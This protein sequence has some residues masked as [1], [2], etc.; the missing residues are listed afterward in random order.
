MSFMVMRSEY[1]R[2][3]LLGFAAKKKLM[4]GKY[5][6][7]QN[8]EKKAIIFYII[9]VYIYNIFIAGGGALVPYGAFIS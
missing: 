5:K 8:W 7:K 1:L 4:I 6:I 2:I 3:F 9:S